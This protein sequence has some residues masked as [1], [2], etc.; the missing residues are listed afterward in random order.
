MF[1]RIH[2]SIFGGFGGGFWIQNRSKIDSDMKLECDAIT[3]TAKV[4]FLEDVQSEMLIFES[5]RSFQERVSGDH[6][7]VE[8]RSEQ[9]SKIDIEFD[10]RWEM[11]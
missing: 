5:P 8:N 11:P 9:P 10:W 4:R 7:G 1:R 6:I 3:M 2:G